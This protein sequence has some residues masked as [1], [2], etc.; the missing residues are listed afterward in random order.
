MSYDVYLKLYQSLVEPVLYY[1]AGLWG[2]TVWK[3]VQ[4]I[5]NKAC[6]LFLGS[7]SNASNVSVQGDMGINST[8]YSVTLETV[9]LFHYL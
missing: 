5:Q 2:H 4:T 6:R 9:R 1:G 7:S 3:E 8:K